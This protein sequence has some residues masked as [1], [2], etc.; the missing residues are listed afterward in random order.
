MSKEKRNE[1]K[2]IGSRIRH[3]RE[4]KGLS[5]KEFGELFD[6][7]ASKGVVSN[8]ENG[9]NLPNAERQKRIAE[10][11]GISVDELLRGTPIER[12]VDKLL[13]ASENFSTDEKL[14]YALNMLKEFS[15]MN[16]ALDKVIAETSNEEHRKNLIV[17][18]ERQKDI[19]GAFFNTLL[20]KEER[21]LF[22]RL[23]IKKD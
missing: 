4:T 13:E 18:S 6:P 20:T 22:E 1:N 15:G 19:V 17:T 2:V 9:Y 3:I 10:L 14:L 11:G 7:I 5:M 21:E 16:E 23:F 12:S 8:W